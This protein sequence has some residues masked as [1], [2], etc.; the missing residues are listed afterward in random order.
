MYFLKVK[1]PLHKN[2]KMGNDSVIF[3]TV[4]RKANCAPSKQPPSSQNTPSTFVTAANTMA[5]SGSG[6]DVVKLTD[7]INSDRTGKGNAM[8]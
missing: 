2:G 8:L 6:G 1:S 5:R 4:F 7:S 3:L